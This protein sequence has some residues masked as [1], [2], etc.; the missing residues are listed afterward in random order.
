MGVAG[1]STG[2]MDGDVRQCATTTLSNESS[3]AAAAM[4]VAS[5]SPAGNTSNCCTLKTLKILVEIDSCRRSDDAWHV[6]RY[7]SSLPVACACV[8]VQRCLVN[9][10]SDM[11]V[12][13]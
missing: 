12:V 1:L 10:K 9:Q 8:C 11:A 4:A 13:L 7:F 5:S 3:M 6:D 2:T